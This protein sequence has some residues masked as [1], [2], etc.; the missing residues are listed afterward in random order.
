[1]DLGLSYEAIARLQKEKGEVEEKA[2]K[3]TVDLERKNAFL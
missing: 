2:N 3:F 1:M